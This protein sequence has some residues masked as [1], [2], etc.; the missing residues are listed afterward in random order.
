MRDG[1]CSRL[2]QHPGC[3]G[4]NIANFLRKFK[5]K[6]QLISECAKAI[7]RN[8]IPKNELPTAIGSEEPSFKCSEPK[9]RNHAVDSMFWVSLTIT[10]HN[11]ENM[12]KTQMFLRTARRGKQMRYYTAVKVMQLKD[13]PLNNINLSFRVRV[14]QI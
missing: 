5:K 2:C 4:R 7:E 11:L 12:A 1:L 8:Q 14:K 3:Y 6:S 10:A 9:I 13:L